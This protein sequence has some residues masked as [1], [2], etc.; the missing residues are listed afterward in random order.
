[1]YTIKWLRNFFDERHWIDSHRHVIKTISESFD[2]SNDVFV[3][4]CLELWN[5]FIK[6]SRRTFLSLSSRSN[7]IIYTYQSNDVQD[8]VNYALPMSFFTSKSKRNS[9]QKSFIWK[10]NATGRKTW[11][12]RERKKMNECQ[13]IRKWYTCIYRHIH[14]SKEHCDM[15]GKVIFL[16]LFFWYLEKIKTSCLY[17]WSLYQVIY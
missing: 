12:G 4:R 2:R 10:R 14:N 1:M 6:I 9:H 15:F 5:F 17:G 16:L 3:R 13:R 7:I 8:I 11:Q